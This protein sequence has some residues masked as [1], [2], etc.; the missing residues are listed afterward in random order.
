M[1]DIS[2]QEIKKALDKFFLPQVD[3]VI[4]IAD[5]GAIPASLVANKLNCELRIIKINY[6]DEQN[7]PRS[8]KPQLIKPLKEKIENKKILLVDDVSVS[9]KTLNEARELFPKNEIITFVMKGKAD[10][11]LFPHFNECVNWPWKI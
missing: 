5:G 10:F 7:K 2:F 11:V 3:L 4:G 8:E 9:G 6:R 1:I